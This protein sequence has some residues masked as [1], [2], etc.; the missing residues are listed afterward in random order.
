METKNMEELYTNAGIVYGG[1]VHLGSINVLSCAGVQR[2]Y[3]M[4]LNCKG[5][6]FVRSYHIIK[7][8][9]N[10]NAPYRKCPC[11]FKELNGR[12]R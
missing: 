5:T 1:L 12:E 4:K 7:D 11:C 9:K 6:E 10:I 8:V 3:Q 2:G